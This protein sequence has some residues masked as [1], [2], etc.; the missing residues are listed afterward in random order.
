MI[1]LDQRSREMRVRI[2]FEINDV[3]YLDF[4]SGEA[5]AERP[6]SLFGME[7]PIGGQQDL[8]RVSTSA[9]SAVRKEGCT[10]TP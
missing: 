2:G 7:G 10:E 4:N 5:L 8:H 1:F 6:C 9:C 3:E